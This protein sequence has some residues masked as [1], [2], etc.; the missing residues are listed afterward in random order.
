MLNTK[1]IKEGGVHENDE[2]GQWELWY[3][4]PYTGEKAFMGFSDYRIDEAH[5]ENWL[6]EHDILNKAFE[7]GMVEHAV[8]MFEVDSPA[9]GLLN[10]TVH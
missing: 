8:E 7:S 3:V 9:D 1:D 2:E 6:V 4:N 5:K 10:T